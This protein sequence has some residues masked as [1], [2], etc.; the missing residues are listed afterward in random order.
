[1][2]E[3]YNTHDKTVIL[4]QVSHLIV[5]YLL[6]NDKKWKGQMNMSS[7]DG[8]EQ[9]VYRIATY[10]PLE[11]RDAFYENVK[12]REP[13]KYN[14]QRKKWITGKASDVLRAFIQLYNESSVTIDELHTMVTTLE[15]LT[16]NRKITK[17]ATP[18]DRDSEQANN[19]VLHNGNSTS[20]NPGDATPQS[21]N[22]DGDQ[23]VHLDPDDTNLFGRSCEYPLHPTTDSLTSL[24]DANQVEQVA[25]IDLVSGTGHDAEL[26]MSLRTPQNSTI[27]QKPLPLHPDEVNEVVHAAIPNRLYKDKTVEELNRRHRKLSEADWQNNYAIPDVVLAHFVGRLGRFLALARSLST[28]MRYYI[29]TK[30]VVVFFEEEAVF[31]IEF[32]RPSPVLYVGTAGVLPYTHRL[33]MDEAFDFLPKFVSIVHAYP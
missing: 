16:S 12:C 8:T 29:S 10:V 18:S 28:K 3:Y 26:S 30:Q 9:N 19:N 11:E 4:S 24:Q 33:S 17:E 15:H 25:E 13:L 27:H 2:R 22:G 14:R 21:F 1:V 7:K 31:V 23:A 20:N 32:T 6:L 5:V